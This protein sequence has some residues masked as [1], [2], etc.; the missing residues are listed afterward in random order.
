M[1][2]ATDQAVL[3]V[4]SADVQQILRAVAGGAD[5]R[6]TAVRVLHAAAGATGVRDG[7][8]LGE[9]ESLAVLGMPSPAMESAAR[10]ALETGRPAR[11]VEDATGRS[12]LAVP[13]RA[14]GTAIAALAVAGEHSRLDPSVLSLLADALAVGVMVRP[15][16]AMG[17]TELVDAASYL[18]LADD[19]RAA[20]LDLLVDRFGAR[21]GCA[22]TA[23]A[24]G[25]MRVSAARHLPGPALQA[26]FDAPAVRDLLS[27]PSLRIER[28]GSASALALGDPDAALAAI[29]IGRAGILLVLLPAMPDPGALAALS[30]IGRATAAGCA[31]ADLRR[32]VEDT[33]GMLASLAAITPNP[34]LV[35]GLAGEILHANA[36]GARLR[37]PVTA[38]DGAEVT[39]VDTAGVERVY[40][41]ARAAVAGYGEAIVLHDLTAAREIERIKTDLIAVIGHELR[42]PL[43]ILRGGVRTLAKRGTAISEDA[44]SSTVD[45]MNRNVARLEH[46]IED[47]LFVS[48]VSEG[49]HAIDVADHDLGAL[50][51]DFGGLRV[52]VRRPDGP[53]PVRCDPA[54]VRRAIAH[55]LDNALKHSEDEVTVELRT[56]DGE[57]EVSVEDRGVGI[58][59]GD[60]PLL[61]SRFQ[62]LDGTATRATGGTGLGLY[63]ARRIVEAHGGRIWA[64]S[65]LGQGSRFAF[66][67]PR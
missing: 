51:D 62:Q 13:A 21:G 18:A 60:L 47:L 6:R 5:A 53:V 8:V 26:A 48:A 41:V 37:E 7:L 9:V 65:R 63:I 50:V 3:S 59:S 38:P 12:I 42:T 4:V 24:D 67:L 46:L 22:L 44:L 29:P 64:T 15:S 61:F 30:A 23:V 2:A 17:G 19:P 66:T 45:A 31:V 35:I 39:M 49:H 27:T 16:R 52:S 34:V 36:A 20:A 33:D 54:H 55:L 57:V 43:T 1:A 25:R 14:G 11:R 58:F 56:G 32:R 28:P 40:R 10:S